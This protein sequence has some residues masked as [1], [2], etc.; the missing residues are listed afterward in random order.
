MD[1]TDSSQLAI[2]Q[3]AEPKHKEKDD[4]RSE[5]DC[6]QEPQVSTRISLR[7][8]LTCIL[9]PRRRYSR[10]CFLNPCFPFPGVFPH[11]DTPGP[12][13]QI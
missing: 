12:E 5:L 1:K 7:V 4:G 13:M 2:A 9:T 8:D 10:G 6:Q 11:P 3:A